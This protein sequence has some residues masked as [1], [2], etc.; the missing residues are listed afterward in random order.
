MTKLF[1]GMLPYDE[2]EG[3][4]TELFG[5]FLD[6]FESLKRTKKILSSR[7]NPGDWAMVLK[8][9]ANDYFAASEDYQQDIFVL[10]N[11]LL[12]IQNEQKYL[13]GNEGVELRRH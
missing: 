13:H 5:R 7:R 8:N 2:I 10:N 11:T 9:M 1:D 4:Q 3:E 6:F 12:K